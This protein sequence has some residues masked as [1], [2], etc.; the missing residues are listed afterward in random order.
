MTVPDG[1]LDAYLVVQRPRYA[2]A[3]LSQLFAPPLQSRPGVHPS[4]VVE[5][6][7]QIAATASVG[8]L[9]FI[10]ANTVIGEHVRIMPQVTVAAG[11]TIGSGSVLHSGV[12][13]GERSVIGRRV[14]IHDNA[15]IGS[16]GFSYATAAAGSVEAARAGKK[17]S[18]INQHIL[19]IHSLGHVVI[20]DDVEI[21]A[22]S[23]IDRATLGTTVIRRGTKIDNLVLIA[24]NNH[25]GADCLIAGQS[26]IAG[27]CR[28]G[29]RVVMG[30]QVG[31]ADH[32]QVGSDTVLAAG[33][34]ISHDVPEKVVMIDS[35]AIPYQVFTERYKALGRLKRVVRDLLDLKKRVLLLEQNGGKSS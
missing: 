9:S 32:V 6:S 3:L 26:G 28:I 20:E 29:E 17:I 24:H 4:A 19:K 8:A 23:T 25:I 35:P 21:G 10:G 5:D 14:I 11:S 2:L 18:A 22:C 15:C 13:I 12:R 30:G 34:G 33:A 7:A 31:I 1:V 27:S 16:D